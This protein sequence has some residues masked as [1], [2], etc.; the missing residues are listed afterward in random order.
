MPLHVHTFK[1]TVL[2]IYDYEKSDQTITFTSPSSPIDW[3]PS[4]AFTS[5]SL[6]PFSK[7]SAMDFN[8]SCLR[9]GGISARAASFTASASRRTNISCN[10]AIGTRM[11][12]KT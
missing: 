7:V 8:T 12:R 10:P 2:Y 6:D 9:S 4:L 3:Y 11:L 1:H 5:A